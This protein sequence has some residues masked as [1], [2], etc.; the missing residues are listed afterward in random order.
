MSW[1]QAKKKKEMR[2]RA[3]K[4]GRVEAKFIMGKC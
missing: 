1:E 3:R 4:E 2:S